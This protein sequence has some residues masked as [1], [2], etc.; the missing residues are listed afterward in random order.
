MFAK[1]KNSITYE[2][3]VISLIVIGS[4]GVFLFPFIQPNEPVESKVVEL[5]ITRAAAKEELQSHGVSK[6]YPLQWKTA[7]K[8]HS[9]CSGAFINASGDILTAKHCTEGIESIDVQTFDA[10]IYTATV[11]KQSETHDIALIHID[12]VN[13]PYFTL[14]MVVKRG[15][16]VFA[17][18]SPLGIT[19]TL[20]T[21]IVANLTGDLTLIDCGV[22]PGN[23]GCPLFNKREE[24]VGL[25]TAG[26]WVGFGT[27][28][29]NIVQSLDVIVKFLERG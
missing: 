4:L 29:L 23:S 1:P 11:V 2:I 12:K 15:E 9:V 24:L 5:H 7:N 26:Y 25:V 28:H 20:S 19:N 21:G 27:T 10:H 14:G 16:Q 3:I 6:I 22:L 18:G 8:Q 13:S 17:L